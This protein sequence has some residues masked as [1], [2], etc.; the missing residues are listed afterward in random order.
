MKEYLNLWTNYNQPHSSLCKQMLRYRSS[1]IR[2]VQSRLYLALSEHGAGV[3]DAGWVLL[4]LDT[5]ADEHEP[6][7]LVYLWYWFIDV[8]SSLYS[9]QCKQSQGIFYIHRFKIDNSNNKISIILK[10]IVKTLRYKSN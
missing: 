3:F 7:G 6:G 5:Y 8:V 2:I 4:S 10:R 9:W 1:C